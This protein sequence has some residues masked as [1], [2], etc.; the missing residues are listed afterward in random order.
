MPNTHLSSP[1]EANPLGAVA[2]RNSC[3]WCDIV[4]EVLRE[5]V[6][7]AIALAILVVALW[8]L[9]RVHQLPK[10]EL[11][12]YHREK[13]ILLLALGFLGTVTGYYFGRVPAERHADAARDAAKSAQAREQEV[14]R[15]AHRG[16]S[17]I[18]RKHNDRREDA[19][20]SPTDAVNTA[21]NQAREDL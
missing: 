21:I 9:V 5:S 10:G 11:E 16:L 13:D 15:K 17:D 3:S 4:R 20:P 19:A 2:T 12:V 7:A 14:R 6:P 18:Q 8:M 1:T